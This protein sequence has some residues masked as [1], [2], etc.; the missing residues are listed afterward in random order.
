MSGTTLWWNHRGTTY[1]MAAIATAGSVAREHALS[2]P[3]TEHNIL[4]WLKKSFN[5]TSMTSY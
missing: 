2:Q 5:S 1:K 3:H 4:T